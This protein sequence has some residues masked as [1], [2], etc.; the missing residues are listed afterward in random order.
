MKTPDRSK[1][2]IVR[3]YGVR[4]ARRF[5]SIWFPIRYASLTGFTAGLWILSPQFTGTWRRALLGSIF[6]LLVIVAATVLTRIRSPYLASIKELG[7][8][9]RTA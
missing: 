8:K 9:Q 5:A 1:T 3:K 2:T 6:A 4:G 7:A